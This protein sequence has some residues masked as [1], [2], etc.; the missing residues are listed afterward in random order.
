MPRPRFP[1]EEG[2]VGIACHRTTYGAPCF[3]LNLLQPGDPIFFETDYGKFR[4]EVETHMIVGPK[5]KKVLAPVVGESI[6]TITTCHP[7]YSAAQRYVVRARLVG[8]AVDAD[9]YFEPEPVITAPPTTVPPSTIPTTTVLAAA[10]DTSATEDPTVDDSA[11]E[12]TIDPT[13]STD[14]AFAITDE[15][16]VPSSLVDASG[17]EA[18]RTGTGQIITFGW[19][20]GRA[21]FWTSTL[22]WVLICSVIWIVAWLIARRRRLLGQ[23]VIYGVGF[24]LLF[25]P[26]LYFCFE[27]LAHLLP[28]NV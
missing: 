25:L 10:P 21:S 17:L 11:A 8:P 16:E 18:E 26:A 4:Y 24:V 14:P 5:D 6:L 20:S 15:T 22:V 2:N 13:A 9:L 3:N 7:Q 19:F 1:G 27:N 12:S 28:E 23:A